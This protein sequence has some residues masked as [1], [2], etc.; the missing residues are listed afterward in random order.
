MDQTWTQRG[1]RVAQLEIRTVPPSS[2]ECATFHRHVVRTY[3]VQVSPSLFMVSQAVNEVDVRSDQWVHQL[4]Q[5]VQILGNVTAGMQYEVNT[6]G[7]IS[8]G[9]PSGDFLASIAKLTP[10]YHTISLTAQPQSNTAVLSF[11]GAIVTVGTDLVG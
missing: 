3:L 8:T 2:L 1:S 7:S 4:G 11:E 6:D 5:S 9:T 10:G